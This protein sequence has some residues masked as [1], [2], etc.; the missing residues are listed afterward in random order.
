MVSVAWYARQDSNLRPFA[1]EANALST[2]LRAR[3]TPE[4]IPAAR[5]TFNLP[6]PLARV[7]SVCA[8]WR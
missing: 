5:F 7:S 1:P 2:E 4:S 6:C 3:I 8:G